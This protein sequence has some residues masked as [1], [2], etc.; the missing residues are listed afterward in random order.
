MSFNPKSPKDLLDAYNNGLPGGVCDLD[1]TEK[2]LTQ[3]PKPLFGDF[4]SMIAG[5][6]KG[7]LSLPF[8]SL[9][10]R[11]PE[12]GEW[13]RQTEGSCV[14]HG[15]RNA[16]DVSRSYEIDV[17]KENESFLDHGAIEGIY[18]SRGHGGE[19]MSCSQAARFISTQ[20]GLLIRKKYGNIDLRVYNGA[21]ASSWGRRGV[22]KTIIE[23]GKQNPVR[24]VSLIRS[25]SEARDALA[26]GYAIAICS[27]YGF[28]STRDKNGISKRKGSW[29]HCM[30][31]IGCDDTHNRL[32]ETLFLIANSW[33]RWNGGPRIHNQP[34]GSFW[35]REED[36]AGM[37]AQNGAWV[38]SNVDG[39]PP[40]KINWSLDKVF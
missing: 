7:V 31:I 24:S 35:I 14:G 28:S 34:H 2:L 4:S 1:D 36:A 6:G 39:F 27:N 30:S 20:C 19:G 16:L 38:I 5:S 18:G 11:E 40:Q 12:F 22:P 23:A 8:L 37:L 25:I 3:L 26:N 15:F 9:L 13:E 32:N 17:R 33:G 21:L 10:K 29:A